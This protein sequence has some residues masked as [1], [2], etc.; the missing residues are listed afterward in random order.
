MT[1]TVA[2]KAFEIYGPF[3]KFGRGITSLLSDTRGI[4]V[5]SKGAPA[6]SARP[7]KLQPEGCNVL[8]ALGQTQASPVGEW[9]D[10]GLASCSRY[11]EDSKTGSQHRK[12][13]SVTTYELFEARVG[14]CS[15][16]HSP[17]AA[18]ICFGARKAARLDRG[19]LNSGPVVRRQPV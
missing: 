17:V 15:A 5:P 18:H 10:V 7:N 16:R 4:L 13:A 1:F 2:F 8:A 3:L 9:V 12:A 6:R 11:L 19:L 14:T